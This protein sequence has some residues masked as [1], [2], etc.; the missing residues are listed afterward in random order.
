MD[1]SALW[2][3]LVGTLA[4]TALPGCQMMGGCCCC[5]CDCRQSREPP[6]LIDNHTCCKP[7]APAT[8]CGQPQ[9]LATTTAVA[10]GPTLQ[11]L[12]EPAPKTRRRNPPVSWL[13]PPSEV[14]SSVV[15]KLPPPVEVHRTLVGWLEAGAEHGTWFLRCDPEPGSNRRGGVI[16]LIAPQPL[17]GCRAGLVVQ[18]EG[19]L[20]PYGGEMAFQ[21]ERIKR[22]R[23]S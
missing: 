7:A 8:A 23:P 17:C 10:Q 4:A 13:P 5:C 9:E 18:V 2:F 3:W 21:V 19:F 15:R 20:T 22:V 1:R 16:Q 14:Q 11:A 6:L 12:P